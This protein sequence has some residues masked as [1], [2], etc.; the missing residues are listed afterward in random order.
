MELIT[1]NTQKVTYDSFCNGGSHILRGLYVFVNVHS[2]ILGSDSVDSRHNAKHQRHML[3]TK[4]QCCMW[5][6][7]CLGRVV[8]AYVGLA[9][10]LA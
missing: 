7:T 9:S 1:Q 6:T 2:H 5:W 3:N 8:Q 4:V 10:A